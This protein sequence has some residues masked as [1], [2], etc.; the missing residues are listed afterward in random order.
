MK[1]ERGEPGESQK[2]GERE[3]LKP[4]A[5]P[6]PRSGEAKLE[7]QLC[8]TGE[9]LTSQRLGESGACE[10]KS[11]S[12][13]L[14]DCQSCSLT[15]AACAVPVPL[16]RGREKQ[17]SEG[18]R[19]AAAWLLIAF[20]IFYFD[21]SVRAF[22]LACSAAAAA[23]AAVVVVRFAVPSLSLVPHSLSRFI[24]KSE[25]D[26]ERTQTEQR[27]QSAVRLHIKDTHSQTHAGIR[28][29]RGVQKIDQIKL[30]APDD[31]A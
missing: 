4:A 16:I 29:E 26:C 13:S 14:N 10:Q 22:M 8:S 25:R 11:E 5:A 31:A 30:A 20:I 19:V 28:S 24:P 12:P 15:D 1:E 18:G 6:Q 9:R 17:A 21:S 2:E 27:L 3:R 23:A 7:G